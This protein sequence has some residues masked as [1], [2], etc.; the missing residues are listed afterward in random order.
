MVI[1]MEKGE[2]FIVIDPAI[3]PKL[4]VSPDVRMIILICLGVGLGG[5]IGLAWILEH[6]DHSYRDDRVLAEHTGIPVLATVPFVCTA[7]HRRKARI[8]RFAWASASAMACAGYLYGIYFV[9]S[10]DIVIRVSWF[11]TGAE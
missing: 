3:P 6:L 9:K 10:H 1:D 2:Q 7:M 5:G 4:P 11:T 8:K